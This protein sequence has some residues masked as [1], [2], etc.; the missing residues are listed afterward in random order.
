MDLYS[1]FGKIVVF[2]LKRRTAFMLESKPFAV[3]FDMISVDN[4]NKCMD[5]FY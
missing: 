3:S 2:A 4:A 1:I 5:I